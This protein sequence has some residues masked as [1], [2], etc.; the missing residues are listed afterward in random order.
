M[1]KKLKDSLSIVK[2]YETTRIFF[3][4]HHNQ[5]ADDYE[6][7][8]VRRAP[9][10]RMDFEEYCFV[11]LHLMFKNEKKKRAETKLFLSESTDLL[12]YYQQNS[13]AI[14]RRWDKDCDKTL[15]EW[16]LTSYDRHKA[17]SR[18]P[19]MLSDFVNDAIAKYE[20]LKSK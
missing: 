17:D 18:G 2:F 13:H 20:K 10:H 9:E 3:N 7:E 14:K 16:V 12:L 11:V 6:Q 5:L 15:F 8:M 4:Q 19:I 1:T